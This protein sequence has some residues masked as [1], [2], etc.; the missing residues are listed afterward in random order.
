MRLILCEPLGADIALPG[1]A[2]L[3]GGYRLLPICRPDGPENPSRHL[4]LLTNPRDLS[5]P[6][7]Q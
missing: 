7:L 5:K 3:R 4:E 2:H 1:P 6:D